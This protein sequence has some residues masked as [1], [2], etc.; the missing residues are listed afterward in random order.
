[1]S[2]IAQLMRE[3]N[4]VPDAAAAL[5]DDEFSALL[6]LTRTRSGTVD[7]QERE[8]STTSSRGGRRGWVVAAVAFATIIAVLGVAILLARPSGDAPPASTPTTTAPATPTTEALSQTTQSVTST[9]Q[10]PVVSVPSTTVA[11]TIDAEA[12]AYVEAIAAELNAGEFEAAGASI[13]AA[14]EFRS[15]GFINDPRPM[16]AGM[17]EY[18][19]EMDS[20][21][22]VTDCRTSSTS[23]I[24]RCIL[25]RTSEF[26]PFDPA[27]E[28]SI[29]QLRLD[30][31]ELAFATQD[32]ERVG[33]WW[34]AFVEF[35][36]WVD[37]TYP[38]TGGQLDNY[39]D[40]AGAAALTKE[41]VAEWKASLEG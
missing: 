22:E 33:S 16:V 38:G 6:L 27:P 24:T 13:L 28:T 14:K 5:P 36:D 1:M 2:D 40:A 18:W 23:G 25:S 9:T 41:Y 7:V 21:I 15:A 3:A 29:F 17:Y 32:P 26:E 37:L 34:T 39:T 11:P 8:I 35:R 10:A 31:G 4:P 20:V 30:N 12:V 19:T